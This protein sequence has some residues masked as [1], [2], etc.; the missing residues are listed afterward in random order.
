[1]LQH[2]QLINNQAITL[3]GDLKTRIMSIRELFENYIGFLWETFMYDMEV[4]SKGWLYYWLLIPAF[5]YLI[6]FLC[7]WALLLFI[8]YCPFLA[9]LKT[10]IFLY[11]KRLQVKQ[12][13]RKK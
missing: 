10:F 5:C 12:I 2:E 1:V 7:K 9:T 11:M 6:F 4:F 3:F 8:F 13:K